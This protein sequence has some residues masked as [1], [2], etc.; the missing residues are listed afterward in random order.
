[1][2]FFL[3]FPCSGDMLKPYQLI[4]LNWLILLHRHDVNGILADEMGLVGARAR[5]CVCVC[6][7][8]CV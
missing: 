7:C 3:S 1:V 4:G 5:A 2:F 8:L 6:V